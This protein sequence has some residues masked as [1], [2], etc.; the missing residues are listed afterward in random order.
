M[1]VRI[2][3]EIV[4]TQFH[5]EA[6]A[7]EFIVRVDIYKNYGYFNPERAG[8][9]VQVIRNIDTPEPKKILRRFIKRYCIFD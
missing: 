7:D 8:E 9:L 1:A 2:S 3:N 5:P 4:G 6:D